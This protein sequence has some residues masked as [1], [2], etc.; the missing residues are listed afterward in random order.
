MK[1]IKAPRIPLSDVASACLDYL[2][3]DPEQLADFMQTAGL[4]PDD[5][6]RAT[7]D[8]GL[9]A[10]LIDYFAHNET[11]LTALCANRGW[12]TS[13]VMRHYYRLNPDG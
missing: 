1:V 13:A 12:P 3:A 7:T 11:L 9:A 6:R 2:S 4:A 10:G 5:I 8:G